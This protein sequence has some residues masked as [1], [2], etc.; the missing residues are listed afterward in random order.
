ML[1]IEER[2]FGTVTVLKISLYRCILALLSISES[3]QVSFW[4]CYGA[5]LHLDAESAF[6]Q[7]AAR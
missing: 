7:I 4:H 2:S 5:I 1:Y 3:L 6:L